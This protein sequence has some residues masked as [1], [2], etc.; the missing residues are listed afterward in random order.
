MMADKFKYLINEH[1][2]KIIKPKEDEV[3][4]GVILY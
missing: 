1:T 2:L 3:V 4:E